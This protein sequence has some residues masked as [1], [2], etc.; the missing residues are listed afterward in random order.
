MI[1]NKLL[2]LINILNGPEKR[3]C[4]VFLKSPY[5]NQREDVTRLWECLLASP[6]CA[7]EEA[8]SHCYPGEAFDDA[9]WR[10]LQSFLLSRIE[11][12]LAQRA[13]E[14]NPVLAEL[15]LAEVY[16][17]RNEAKAL[18]HVFRRAAARLDKRPRDN[19]FYQLRYRLEWEQYAAME[20]PGQK[21]DNNLQAVGNALD[22]YLLGAKLR[23]A[24]LMESHRTVFN[25]DFDTSFLPLLLQFL[26]ESPL[27]EEPLI[28]LYYH[29]YKALRGGE[30]AHFRA[31][32]GE[33]ERQSAHLPADER[34]IFLLLAIN[35][36]IRRLNTG[37][38]R[39]IREAF[40]LYGVGLDTGILL[41]N[42]LLS[43]F[44]FKNIVALGLR[45]EQFDWVGQF[46][47]Q[48]APFLEEKYRD[49]NR[50]YNL[51]RLHY[52][53]KQYQMAM[54]LLA[55]VDESD[56]MLNLDSRV[57]LLKMYYE[58]GEWDALDALIASFKIFLLRKK[59][60]LG[61]HQAHYLNIIRFVQ[62]LTRLRH[63][64]RQAVAALREAVQQQP[65]LIERE[66]LLD[67]LLS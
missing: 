60:S 28:A 6:A 35:F 11:N 32:R 43:R 7:A 13:W 54:P 47:E 41:E 38:P 27:K 9:R 37:E 23:L 62:K 61:Y 22:L 24:C 48:Y 56:L 20:S 57:M 52:A 33:L 66:W 58:T 59:K 55:R 25:T 21:R 15:H 31:F 12:F 2:G 26:D 18:D 36:C 1:E 39:F 4:S 44:A 46:I 49:P 10:H 50:L 8:F 64:D 17:R 34:R 67:M 65:A 63:N 29:C 53:R 5:F 16:R 3:E 40:D 45:L 42:G 19:E 14:Q 51:A 30:E